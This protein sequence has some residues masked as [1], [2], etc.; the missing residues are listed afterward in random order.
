ME[1]F[2][3]EKVS[4]Q[5]EKVTFA[6]EIGIY[7]TLIYATDTSCYISV[8]Y[9]NPNHKILEVC[10]DNYHKSTRFVHIICSKSFRNN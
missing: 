1:R 4:K 6:L 8:I 9:I 3:F 2:F 10:G 5:N 7:D